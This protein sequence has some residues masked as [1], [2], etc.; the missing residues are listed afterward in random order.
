VI[1]KKMMSSR[2]QRSCFHQRIFLIGFGLLTIL[3]INHLS[4]ESPDLTYSNP[5]IQ[6][7]YSDPDVIRVGDD[8]YLISSSF[9]QAPGVPVL[10]SRNL[11]N[12]QIIGYAVPHLPDSIY[13]LPQPGRGIWAPALRYHNGEYWV[14]YGDPDLGIF[15]VKSQN[16]A[17]P[18]E[19]P[20][21]VKQACGWIDPCPFWDDDGQAYLIHAWAKS[22]VGFN[23]ILTLHK[24]SSDGRQILD[25]GVT[26]FDGHST[27]PTIE[28]PKLYKRNGYY[29]IFA[30]AGGVTN[31]WQTVLRSKNILGPYEDKI[32]LEQGTTAING[33]HQGAWVETQEGE[34]WFIHFQDK[35][36]YGRIIHL[37]PVEWLDDWPM[38]GIDLDGNGIGEPV[39]CFRRPGV[40]DSISTIKIQTSDEFESNSL[41]L[42]WQWRA[43]FKS[44]W[45]TLSARSGYLRLFTVNPAPVCHNLGDLPNILTQKFPAE[46]FMVTTKLS[47]HPDSND[48]QAGLIIIGNDY[49]ALKVIHRGAQYQLT[50]AECAEIEKGKSEIISETVGLNKPEVFLKATVG[51]G[52]VCTFSYSTDGEKYL[53][54]G[55][56]FQAV[57][58][59][60]VGSQIGIFATT[61][62]GKTSRGYA[63]FDFFRVMSIGKAEPK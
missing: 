3:A 52:A 31:G 29:Y 14:Y 40:D 51:E 63:D 28:G 59:K 8:F 24:L 50:Y 21:L 12:W 32:V 39:Q 36:A 56:K 46:A 42:Q 4:A 2:H 53:P 44:E 61:K 57:K 35:G 43:N 60:W 58:G 10:H 48:D 17:G 33:P 45:F 20:V 27:H 62:P 54:L 30:P 1:I 25:E 23:S 6:A 22:R 5:I 37:Q 55:R 18:W 47:F 13:D 11:V 34:S 7:D 19:P 9:S 49:A 26:V 15:M 38:I 41:G 16:P